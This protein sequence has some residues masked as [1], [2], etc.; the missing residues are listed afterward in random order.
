MSNTENK[1][2]QAL[3]ACYKVIE[4]IEDGTV[5]VSSS[6]LLCKRIARLV[7]DCKGQEW[8]NYT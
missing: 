6:L 8:L 7:N 4:G 1:R 5:S 2:A 3:E